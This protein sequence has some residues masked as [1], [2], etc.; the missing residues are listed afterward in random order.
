MTL[1]AEIK[2]T[3]RGSIGSG[4]VRFVLATF[5]LACMSG[6]FGATQPAAYSFAAND[7]FL[8]RSQ[9]Y[10]RWAALTARHAA[11][12]PEI[13]ACIGNIVAC[14]SSLKGYREIV[15]AGRD[16]YRVWIFRKRNFCN[17]KKHN[18]IE[19]PE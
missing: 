4:I 18:Q 5:V 3:Q 15:L 17:Q 12:M 13:E 9:E 19:K 14:P 10:P 11:Q 16:L 6:A 2:V 7:H 1:I 8:T